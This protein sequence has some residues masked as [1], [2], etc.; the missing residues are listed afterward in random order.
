[1]RAE[2]PRSSRAWVRCPDRPRPLR[3]VSAAQPMLHHGFSLS[4]TDALRAA[5]G[6]AR[7][8]I[9]CPLFLS[10]TTSQAPATD[11]GRLLHR[12]PGPIQ[13]LNSAS[14]AR[15]CSIPKLSPSGAPWRCPRGR[16]GRPSCA[17]GPTP[18]ALGFELTALRPS[19]SRRQAARP[20]HRPSRTLADADPLS[21][22]AVLTVD[23]DDCA[24][25]DPRDAGAKREI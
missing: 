18:A 9:W 20:A 16:P 12:Y 5:Y 2:E 23:L 14:V 13:E 4:R 25:L 1:M 6:E 15:S 19:G 3:A 7:L 8:P 22:T 21:K 11:L 17:G 10:V 24:V